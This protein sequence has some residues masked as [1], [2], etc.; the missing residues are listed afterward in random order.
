[1]YGTVFIIHCISN[2]IFGT[3]ISFLFALKYSR[4]VVTLWSKSVRQRGR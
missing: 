4:P 3:G 1:M 2:T